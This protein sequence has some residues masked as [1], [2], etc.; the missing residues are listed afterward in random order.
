MPSPL[1]IATA[2]R[3]C[4]AGHSV[5][6]DGAIAT[7]AVM[8]DSAWSSAQVSPASVRGGTTIANSIVSVDVMPVIYTLCIEHTIP[9]MG[10]MDYRCAMLRYVILGG[11]YAAI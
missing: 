9:V 2:M 3:R 6:Q 7:R 10:D 11:W 5:S 4:A 8:L 1:Q